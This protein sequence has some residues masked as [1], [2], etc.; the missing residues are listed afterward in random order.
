V[1]ATEQDLSG[2][3]DVIVVGSGAGGGMAS[4]VL[5]QAGVKVLLLE[6]GRYYDPV[7]ETRMFDTNERAPLRGVSTPDKPWGYY[8][9]TVDGGWSVP[10]EPYTVAPGSEDFLWWRPRMLGGRTNHW[11]RIS[12]RFGSYDFKP[13]SRDGLGV[14]WPIEYA[15]LAPYYDKV[16]TLV[17]VTGQAEGWEN[18]PDSPPGVHQPPPPPRPYER[19]VMRG[20]KALQIPVGAMRAAVLTRP[21]N[22]R[23]ACLYATECGRG[24]AIR[25][26][27]QT[28]TVLLPPALKTGNLTIRANALVYEVVMGKGG[29]AEAV[30]FVDRKT[31][32]HHSVAAKAIVLSAGACESARILLNSKSSAHPHGVGNGAGIVGKYLMDTVGTELAANF[33]ALEGAPLHNDDGISLPHIFV[34]WWGYQ[35]QARK[36]LDFPRGYHIEVYGGRGMP[37]AGIGELASRSRVAFGEGLREELRRHYG[38]FIGFAGRG[39]MIPNEDCYCEIDPVVKDKWGIP[40]LRFHWKWAEP[41]LRQATHQRKTFLELIERLGGVPTGDI[42]TDGRK[43]IKKGGEIIHEVG[44]ARMGSDANSSVVDANGAV[45]GVKNLYVMDGAVFPSNPDKNPTLSILALTW[46]NSEHL[47]AAARQGAL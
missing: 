44:T 12:P 30:R 21:L 6:A 27:F 36:E 39:E 35:Q 15:D 13:Y 14:D 37:N 18:L 33:P 8:D 7:T 41:E 29:R 10:G 38:T 4:Y 19:F 5:T 1:A 26:N 20:L 34:P 16:E 24:C 17:G 9:A 28:P 43:H 23:A 40:V 31:G 2:E 32:A 25:A 22:E 47:V 3:F 42:S 11:G 45:W 46:R